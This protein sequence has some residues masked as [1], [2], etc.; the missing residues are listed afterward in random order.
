L[1]IWAILGSLAITVAATGFIH[2]HY[3]AYFNL[4]SGGPDRTPPRLIDSN[5]DWGQDLINLQDWVNEHARGEPI[6][7][8][9]FGQI[10]PALLA[11]RGPALDWFIPPVRP[12]GLNTLPRQPGLPPPQVAG[13]VARL[14]P[15]YYAISAS[16]V[17]GLRW[18]LYDPSPFAW[19]PPWNSAQDAFSYFRLLT[20]IRRIGHSIYVYKLGQ[21]DVDRVRDELARP[22]PRHED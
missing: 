19:E 10:H 22:I 13:P 9:Y 4:A 17:Q 1:A 18:R 14:T 16:I 11:S 15:G 21:D 7:L 12:G 20:P 3:L 6:G 2:P 5:L 8:A